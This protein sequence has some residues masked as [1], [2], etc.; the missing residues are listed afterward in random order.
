MPGDVADVAAGT[1]Y[2]AYYNGAVPTDCIV[3]MQGVW[4][5][6]VVLGGGVPCVVCGGVRGCSVGKEWGSRE[7]PPV[8]CVSHIAAAHL[9][10]HNRHR[11]NCLPPPQ[12]PLPPAATYTCDP[13][14]SRC[15]SNLQVAQ[16]LCQ[17]RGQGQG[18]GF[19]L[20]RGRQG[21]GNGCA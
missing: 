16:M 10:Y 18:Q 8:R 19:V 6:A 3:R 5:A 14:D 15:N 20:G 1:R 4:G 11:H 21:V 9:C 12:L 2:P 7:I 17:V 13:S